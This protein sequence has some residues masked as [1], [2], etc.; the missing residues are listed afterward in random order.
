MH[1]DVYLP[2]SFA[3]HIE[4]T[5]YCDDISLTQY[6]IKHLRFFSLSLIIVTWHYKYFLP[7]VKKKQTKKLEKLS[8]FSYFV[9]Y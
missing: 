1:V 4:L 2:G 9:K 8:K 3:V 7:G 6:K 5:L